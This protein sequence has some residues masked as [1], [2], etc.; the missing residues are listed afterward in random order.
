MAVVAL[1]VEERLAA[2][3]GGRSVASTGVPRKSLKIPAFVALSVPLFKRAV[4]S[5]RVF[6]RG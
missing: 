6:G 2:T 5:T 4:S 3:D 1:L